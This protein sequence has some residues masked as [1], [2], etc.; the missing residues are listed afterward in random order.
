MTHVVHPPELELLAAIMDREAA[1]RLAS[2]PG[3]WRT[4]SGPELHTLGLS[5]RQSQSVRALQALVAR[6][7]PTVDRFELA[8]AHAVGT[9]YGARLAG[10]EHEVVLAIA[11]DGRNCLLAELE[12][13][14]GGLHGAALTPRDVF[15]PLIRANASA[16]ILVHNHPSGDPTPNAEDVHLTQAVSSVGDIIG[17]P[18]LDH[19]VIGARGGGW[20]S[21]FDI[22]VIE[23]KENTHEQAVADPAI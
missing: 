18:L 15:R 3:G 4:L 1:L 11:V 20:I 7:Y 19:V 17:I 9:L 14:R 16:F 10:L 22:G 2:A 23:S 8:S 13:A 12:L 5:A 21:L 6:G